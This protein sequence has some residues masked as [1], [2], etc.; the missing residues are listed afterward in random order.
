MLAN[1]DMK[2]P[3]AI[4]L[5]ILCNIKGTETHTHTH[6]GGACSVQEKGGQPEEGW[7]DERRTVK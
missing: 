6:A 4:K 2:L 5:E 1:I 7:M 3:Q